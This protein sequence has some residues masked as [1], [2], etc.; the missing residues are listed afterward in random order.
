MGLKHNRPGW[1]GG[2]FST[3]R[4]WLGRQKK[5][6]RQVPWNLHLGTGERHRAMSSGAI[7][8]LTTPSSAVHLYGNRCA[9]FKNWS[10]H[11]TLNRDD[12]NTNRSKVHAGPAKGAAR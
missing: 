4:R 12:T 8:N 1:P 6:Q 11:S 2:D 3:S 10:F 7:C 5:E 9:T